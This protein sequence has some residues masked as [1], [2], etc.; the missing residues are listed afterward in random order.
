MK[1][2]LGLA[3]A[4]ALSVAVLPAVAADYPVKAPPPPI[5]TWSGFYIGVQAGAGWSNVNWFVPGLV[6]TGRETGSG[7]AIGGT[8]GWNWQ[9]PGS[10][11]VF[12]IEA[13]VS[14]SNILVGGVVA[15][16]GPCTTRLDT[17]ATIRGRFGHA[18]GPLLFYLTGGGAWGNFTN[19]V[20]IASFRDDN[21]GWTVGGG[22]EGALGGGWSLKAEYLYVDIDNL[23][24]CSAAVCAITNFAH[25][26]GNILRGGVN[27]KF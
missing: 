23:F 15:C 25:F 9:M 5:W 13:D 10:P 2:L 19:S 24:A 4:G 27:Y 22:L 20:T 21:W 11:W 17:L 6:V 7:G 18:N 16:G 26:R 12:G 14:W 3:L 1:K 8:A